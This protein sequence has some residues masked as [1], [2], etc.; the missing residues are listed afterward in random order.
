M[1]DEKYK[2]RLRTTIPLLIFGKHLKA[3][4]KNYIHCFMTIGCKLHKK[5]KFELFIFFYFINYY[6]NIL[7]L[8]LDKL[9]GREE[10]FIFSAD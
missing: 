7:T 9:L 10:P 8:S 6:K 3:E 4:G 1:T 2:V 5:P